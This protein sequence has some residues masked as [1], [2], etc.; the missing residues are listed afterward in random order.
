MYVYLEAVSHM[1]LCHCAVVMMGM[2]IITL[3]KR[4]D[5]GNQFACILPFRSPQR[6]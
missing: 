6:L 5:K 3:R 1:F 2:D 4:V